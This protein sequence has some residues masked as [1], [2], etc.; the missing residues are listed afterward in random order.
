MKE[1][2]R[3]DFL[4]ITPT[5][6]IAIAIGVLRLS[7]KNRGDSLELFEDN[8]KE[9]SK[10]SESE[11]S[12]KFKALLQGSAILFLAISAENYSIPL[13]SVKVGEVPGA[14]EIMSIAV[15]ILYMRFSLAS[16]AQS[17]YSTAHRVNSRSD[18]EGLVE[19]LDPNSI[20]EYIF[21]KYLKSEQVDFL[22][23]GVFFKIYSQFIIF[24]IVV[25]FLSGSLLLIGLLVYSW[26]AISHGTAPIVLRIHAIALSAFTTTA[27]TLV[28]F[29]I[30]IKFKFAQRGDRLS[31]IL[32]SK[33]ATSNE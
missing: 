29:S 9:W 20:Q 32:T 12:G 26:V 28:L 15:S 1:T 33:K 25:M 11:F 27:A 5:Q 10:R 3:S 24:V 4:R 13:I 16:A 18:Q 14:L 21:S 17:I 22:L 2:N 31:A 6:R 8:L 23:P 7:L 30:S 19:S